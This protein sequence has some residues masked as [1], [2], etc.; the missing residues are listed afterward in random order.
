[1][2]KAILPNGYEIETHHIHTTED[3]TEIWI[4]K[5][6]EFFTEENYKRGAEPTKKHLKNITHHWIFDDEKHTVSYDIQGPRNQ[7][8][9][10]LAGEFLCVSPVGTMTFSDLLITVSAGLLSSKQTT[11]PVRTK[12]S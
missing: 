7:I 3:G 12:S 9:G 8:L 11:P 6:K 2:V 10:I 5:Y 1:M 4:L